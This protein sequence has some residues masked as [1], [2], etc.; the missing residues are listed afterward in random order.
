MHVS[1]WAKDH[2]MAFPW[3]KFCTWSIWCFYF[4][5]SCWIS[6]DNMDYTWGFLHLE[7][8][9]ELSCLE[10]IS[11]H[12]QYNSIIYFR[13]AI[14][15]MCLRWY[16]LMLNS[17][18]LTEFCKFIHR[19]WIFW[20]HIQLVFQLTTSIFWNLWILHFYYP[21]IKSMYI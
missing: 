18:F 15:L 6:I 10:H 17:F 13:N 9:W 2:E 14:V 21:S 19:F 3:F 11:C 5:S 4:S 12:V 1:E 7:M 16:D 20:C 8:V